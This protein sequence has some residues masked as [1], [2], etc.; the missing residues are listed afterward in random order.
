MMSLHFS[1]DLHPIVK[2]RVGMLYWIMDPAVQ[3]VI[4]AY[5]LSGNQVLLHQYDVRSLLPQRIPIPGPVLCSSCRLHS[6][7][8]SQPTV[9][10]AST[11]TTERCR[12][13]IRAALGCDVPFE[14]LRCAPWRMKSQ[15]AR[16]LQRGRVVLCGDAAHSFPPTG[17]LGLNSGIAG[18]CT[19]RQAPRSI[20]P[21]WV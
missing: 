14:Y 2:E 12:E 13:I 3:G 15:V 9:N 19:S 6:E 8:T 5:D 17:G 4:I 11:F 18:E 7:L 21:G 16:Q 1:A 20:H 10:E